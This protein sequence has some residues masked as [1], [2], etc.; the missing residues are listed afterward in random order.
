MR[1]RFV[2]VYYAIIG[3]GKGSHLIS[4]RHQL[5]TVVHEVNLHR[6]E[7]VKFQFTLFDKSSFRQIISTPSFR[8]FWAPFQKL[9]FTGLSLHLEAEAIVLKRNNKVTRVNFP[10]DFFI[11]SGISVH[12]RYHTDSEP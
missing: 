3:A 9:H 12:C 10:N 11:H 1:R 7:P 2:T 4:S 5:H 6:T 8:S